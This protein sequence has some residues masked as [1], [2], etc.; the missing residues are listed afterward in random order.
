MLI[1]QIPKPKLINVNVIPNS[2]KPLISKIDENNYEAK[3]DE[4]AE[5]GRANARLVEMLSEYFGVRKSQVRIVKGLRSRSKVI[6]VS[7]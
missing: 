3:V 5:D 7:C 4:R 1:L 6:Q 2:K